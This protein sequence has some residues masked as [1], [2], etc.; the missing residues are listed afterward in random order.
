MNRKTFLQSAAL[1]A[2]ALA[3]SPLKVF[4]EPLLAAPK[5]DKAELK[6][7]FNESIAPGDSLAAK[8]D[9]MEN[10]GV[11]GLEPFGSGLAGRVNDLQQNL[12]GRNM[13]ISA[14]CAGFSGFPLA[15]DE[16]VR[17]EFDSSM[18]DII[19]AA[20]ELGSVGVIFV[21][22]FNGQNPCLP[23]TA[24]TRAALLEHIKELGAYAAKCN[25]SVILEPLNRR[26]AFFLRQVADAASMC[27]DVAG[28]GVNCMGDF[29]HMTAEET[30]DMGAF[31]SGGKYLNHVHIASRGTRNIPG[32]DGDVDN[33]VDGFRGLKM[34]GYNGYVSYECGAK[35]D[36]NTALPASVKL[37][38]EQWKQA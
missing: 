38:R 13:K 29:W 20:G 36:K 3:I 35:T 37:L 16:A 25:T 17:R 22:A 30:S 28:A 4:S 2:T 8:L 23:H 19:A 21:P 1:G 15:S 32:E 31:L 26:E 11:V 27:R 5:T 7:S 24:E 6:L 10:L 33:Y 14:I 18:R 12:R 34:L 9:F